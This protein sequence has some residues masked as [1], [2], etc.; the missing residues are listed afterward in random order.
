MTYDTQF[1]KDYN[2]RSFTIC[3]RDL[4]SAP[5]EAI[6]NPANSGLSHGGGLA[7]MISDSAGPGLD[8]E[9]NRIIKKIG[10]IPITYAVPSKGYQTGYKHIIHAVGPRMGNGNEEEKVKKT[11]NNSL[12]V[13][14]IKKIKSIAFPAISSGLFGV[15]KDIVAKAFKEAVPDYWLNHSSSKIYKIYLCLTNE[16]FPVF[17][18][19]LD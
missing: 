14:D 17:K 13:A 16:D 5:C 3:I 7:A 19:I 8:E 4:L 10:M 1:I 18:K 6:V 9:C 2:G 15:P 11:I 12:Y